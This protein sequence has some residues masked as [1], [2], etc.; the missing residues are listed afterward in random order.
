MPNLI[1]P[2]LLSLLTALSTSTL[3]IDVSQLFS[4]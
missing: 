1:L 3:G 4:V 2:L